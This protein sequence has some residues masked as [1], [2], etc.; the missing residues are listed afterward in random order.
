MASN[1][2]QSASLSFFPWW[3]TL[4]FLLHPAEIPQNSSETLA[5]GGEAG[6]MG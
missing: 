3:K 2:V 6:P 1:S 5:S 4:V